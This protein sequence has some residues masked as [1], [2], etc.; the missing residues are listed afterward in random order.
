MV[1]K[2]FIILSLILVIVL[3]FAF[4][5]KERNLIE[6]AE[7]RLVIITP[8]NEAVRFEFTQ[9]FKKWYKKKT[10]R[11]VTIDWRVLGG[12]Q[13]VIRYINSQYDNAFQFHWEKGLGRQWSEKIAD[14]FTDNEIVLPE[15]PA[16]D[17]LLQFAR[18]T[19]L[20]SEVSCGIDLLFGGGELEVKEQADRAQI[21][22][23]GIIQKYPD[24]FKEDVIPQKFA[25]VDF[26]D[27]NGLWVGATH[28]GFGIIYN[29]SLIHI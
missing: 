6:D 26:Y 18:R 17:N 19:F 7:E 12:T 1:N 5:K 24:W 13:E 28:S 2:I 16:D 9:G 14:A 29:L 4:T 27:P 10:G 23:S 21:V 3:P 15:N 8:H 22:D 11:T 25:G 20:E